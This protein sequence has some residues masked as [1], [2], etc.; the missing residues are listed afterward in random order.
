[1]I[2]L[3]RSTLRR[4]KVETAARLV[5]DYLDLD[6]FEVRYLGA[7]VPHDDLGRMVERE[8]ADH[9]PQIAPVLD[10]AADAVRGRA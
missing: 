2:V 5:A 8:L 9:L 3:G 1:M 4:L 7:T 10:A 6:G